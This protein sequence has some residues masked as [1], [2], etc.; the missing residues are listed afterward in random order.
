M[1]KR[2]AVALPA[3]LTPRQAGPAAQVSDLPG[4]PAGPGWRLPVPRHPET[5][6]TGCPAA[7]RTVSIQRPGCF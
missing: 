3:Q 5:G 4:S 2:S 1:E 7:V 6:R